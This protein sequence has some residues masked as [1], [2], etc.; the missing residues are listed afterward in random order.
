LHQA[1]QAQ[2]ATWQSRDFARHAREMDQSRAAAATALAALSAA[3][4]ALGAALA[5]AGTELPEAAGSD[6]APGSGTLACCGRALG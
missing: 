1:Q 2:F 3:S 5:A 6:A 4:R